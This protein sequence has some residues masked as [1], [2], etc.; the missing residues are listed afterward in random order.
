MN[1]IYFF[2]LMA[3]SLIVSG[4]QS[5]PPVSQPGAVVSPIESCRQLISLVDLAVVEAGTTDTSVFRI[6][7]FPY[8]RANRFLAEMAAT[9]N[10]PPAID[11][12]L[13][14]MHRLDQE[15]REKEIL[16]LD[17]NQFQ[18]LVNQSRQFTDRRTFIEAVGTCSDR[19]FNDGADQQRIAGDVKD[20]I[21]I[22]TEYRTWRRVVGLY[23][24]VA[25]P[26][27]YAR[28]DAFD[29]FRAW[30]AMP[31]EKLP[32]IGAPVVYG[33]ADRSDDHRIDPVT[34]YQTTP[35]DALGLPRLTAH[36]KRRLIDA[37]APTIVQDTA[38][39]YD[40]IGQVQWSN[41]ELTIVRG[42]PTG[43]FY[44]SQ[45]RFKNRPSLQIN[46]VFWYSHR[47]G[48][49]AP[50]IE[51][52]QLDGLTVRIS[53][54]H[55]GRP[56]MLDIMN[57]CGCYHFFVPD[58]TQIRS[59]KT[60]ALGLDPLVPAWLP[61]QLPDRRLQLM[62]SSGWHQVQHVG[63]DNPAEATVSYKLRPYHELE[64]L[65]DENGQHR[66]MFNEEGIAWGSDRVEPVLFF[67]M[68]IPNVGSM[69]QRG[70]HA[71]KMVGNAHFDDP[72]LFDNTFEYR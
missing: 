67:S 69:R 20:A 14:R 51:W 5:T 63:V 30:H 35:M 72:Q 38:A 41:G 21:D 61:D 71:I 45:G 8:L 29:E 39:G 56:V 2:I 19:L 6:K 37:L 36:D 34:R 27:A 11:Q 70:H 49:S 48:D 15:A 1:R 33:P 50:W 7:G 13:L 22:P 65:A 24:L 40:R 57:N 54:D 43:Y 9:E 58:Q 28:D 60:T 25:L 47:A 52:G 55:T 4:C 68:G 31:P 12:W 59:V 66:S 26:V 16:N 44:L 62:V 23:P 18:R 53:L 3:V 32:S 10:S 46:Y 17:N 42:A 64:M